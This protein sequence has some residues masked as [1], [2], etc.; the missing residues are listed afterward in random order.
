M[1]AT[2]LKR[3]EMLAPQHWYDSVDA[4]RAKQPGIPSRAEAIRQL[5]ERA[6]SAN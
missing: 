2:K 4:W 3:F 5:V 6:L 1:T